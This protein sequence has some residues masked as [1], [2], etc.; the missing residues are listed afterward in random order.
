MKKILLIILT[1]SLWSCS[2]ENDPPEFDKSGVSTWGK[3]FVVARHYTLIDTTLTSSFPSVTVLCE[4]SDVPTITWEYNGRRVN[5]ETTNPRWDEISQKWTV[6]SEMLWDGTPPYND[7]DVIKATIVFADGKTVIRETVVKE[8]KTVNDVF[9]VDF[10]MSKSDIRKIHWSFKQI[11]PNPDIGRALQSSELGGLLYLFEN[12]KLVE[13]CYLSIV[14]LHE[15]IPM[16]SE[17]YN[18][19]FFSYTEICKFPERER[20]MTEGV[21]DK[22]YE[23]NNGRVEFSMRE[24]YDLLQIVHPEITLNEW[25]KSAQAYIGISIRLKK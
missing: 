23:W 7:K 6:R 12:D 17:R 5:G 14:I 2:K 15:N 21:T 3:E 11:H 4:E 8:E 9:D 1:F 13:L 19:E 20:M 22:T 24:R 18:E 10:G 25:D 16:I